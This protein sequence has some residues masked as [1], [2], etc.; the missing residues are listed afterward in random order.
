MLRA[1]SA[2]RM[3]DVHCLLRCFA[4]MPPA[5]LHMPYAIIDICAIDIESRHMMPA[6]AIALCLRQL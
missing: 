3:L 6:F 1:L 4:L 2:T 5:L